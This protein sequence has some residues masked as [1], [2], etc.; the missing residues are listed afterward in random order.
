M[1]IKSLCQVQIEYLSELLLASSVHRCFAFEDHRC[2]A[3]FLF[4][5]GGISSGYDCVKLNVT[6]TPM[7]NITHRQTDRQLHGYTQ[8]YI[9][10]D[11]QTQHKHTDTQTGIDRQTD[12]DRQTHTHTH[13]HTPFK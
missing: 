12:R 2:V 1:S 7:F 13:T 6:F 9:Y 10:S 3:G 8:V 11:R 5:G 4:F